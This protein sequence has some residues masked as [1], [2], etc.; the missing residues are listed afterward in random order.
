M[1]DLMVILTFLA[2][3]SVVTFTVIGVHRYFT[4]RITAE[5]AFTRSLEHQTAAGNEL[6][7][8][9]DTGW[10]P[11][12]YATWLRLWTASG[13]TAAHPRSPGNIAL[14]MV[15]AGAG[16][17]VAVFPGGTTGVVMGLFGAGIFYAFLSLGASKRIAQMEKQLPLLLSGLRS[18]ISAGVTPQTALIDITD[19]IPPPLGNEVAVIRSELITGVSLNTAMS[20]FAKRVPTRQVQ[21]LVASIEIAA[22]SGSDLQP[23]LIVIE[24]I[25][26]QRSRIAGK[27]RSALALVKPTAWMA[28]AA[29]AIALLWTISSD[30]AALGYFFG[31]GFFIFILGCALYGVGIIVVN[32]MMR[33]LA[34][35]AL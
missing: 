5:A 13:R 21:F 2:T 28:Q 3:G 34:S 18:Q 22:S 19:S 14:A 35:K 32:T 10:M 31:S 9:D 23:Q 26:E 6:T 15:I 33:S 4:S 11:P 20:R 1:S 27:I 25:Y 8:R 7:P 29:P 16:F 17:G 24:D 12:T 30:P